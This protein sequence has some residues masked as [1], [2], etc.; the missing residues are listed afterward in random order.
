MRIA[1]AQL[2]PVVG[3]I[4]GNAARVRDMLGQG[5]AE[6]ADFVIFTELVLPGYPPKDLVLR[7]QFVDR[8]IRAVDD[9]AEDTRDGPAAIVGFVDRNTTPRG[10]TLFNAAALLAR[11]ERVATFYKCLLPTYDVFD[12]H[13][14][15]EPGPG[16]KSVDVPAPGGPVRI[17][18]TI[19]EDLWTS[20]TCFAGRR[21]QRRPIEE[22]AADV[23]V[24]GTDEAGGRGDGDEDAAREAAR[25]AGRADREARNRHALDQHKR[26]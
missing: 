23:Q 24:T 26:I 2:N 25:Q 15:F 20:D 4:E 6:R 10:A 11:G 7:D 19:C 8:N 18:V 12:E 14:Y 5:R 13:R 9:I 16:A 17:G 3:D 21:Y 1:L 22:V